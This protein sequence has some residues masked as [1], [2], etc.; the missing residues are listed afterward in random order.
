MSGLAASVRVHI[1]NNLRIRLGIRLLR[2]TIRA[3]FGASL[4][5]L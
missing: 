1:L 4:V 5:K 2:A 3:D